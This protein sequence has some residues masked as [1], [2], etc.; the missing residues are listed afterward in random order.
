MKKLKSFIGN[1]HLNIIPYTIS[2]VIVFF[3][4]TINFDNSNISGLEKTN[5]ITQAVQKYFTNIYWTQF[6]PSSDVIAFSTNTISL[7]NNFGNDNT[8]SSKNQF[9]KDFSGK[10]FNPKFGINEFKIPNGW[11]ATEGMNGDKGVIITIH[12]GTSSE[13]FSK[14]NSRSLLNETMPIMNLIVQD[15]TELKERQKFSLSSDDSGI[16]TSCNSLKPNSTS[17]I[18][19]KTFQIA[20]MK[21]S[22]TSKESIPGIDFGNTEVSKLYKYESPTT[23]Y[24][25]QLILSSEYSPTPAKIDLMDMDKFQSLVDNAA[26]SLIIKND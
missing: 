1:Y 6:A 2:F 18:N 7:D 23:I 4:G 20:L 8:Y 24:I 16:S 21:C 3:I 19:G 12:P 5:T 11:F 25:L 26:Q 14:L 22:T 9:Q 13:F 10:Y 17:I 15:K